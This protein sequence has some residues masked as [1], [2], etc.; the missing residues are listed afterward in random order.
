MIYR[1]KTWRGALAGV[2]L[3]MGRHPTNQKG[4]QLDPW[5]GHMPGLWIRPWF[6]H[7]GEATNQCFSLTSMFLSLSFFLPFSLFKKKMEGIT[8]SSL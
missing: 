4:P 5:L 8:N 6:G 7:T 2:A 1:N 3:F